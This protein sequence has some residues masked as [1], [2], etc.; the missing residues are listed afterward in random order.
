MFVHP[1][2]Q[3]GALANSISYVSNYHYLQTIY[4]S[5]HRVLYLHN[6]GTLIIYVSKRFYK[7]GINEGCM[8]WWLKQFPPLGS[9]PSAGKEKNTC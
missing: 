7:R 5:C 6:M 2:R 1:D 3:Y 8:I 4:H 9:N